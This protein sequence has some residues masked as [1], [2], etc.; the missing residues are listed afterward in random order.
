[1]ILPPFRT[2]Q[3]YASLLLFFYALALQ[4][5]AFFFPVAEV[6]NDDLTY[7]GAWLTELVTGNRWA[8]LL[9]PPLLVAVA[10]ILAN[11]YAD[12]YRLSRTVS[13]F[14]GLLLVLL[15]GLS[16]AFHAFSPHQLCFSFLLLAAGNLG[17]TYKGQSPEV[18][19]FNAGFWLGA[20]SLL[21]P[22]YLL[23]VPACIVGISIFRTVDLRTIMQLLVGVAI[24]YFLAATYGYFRGDLPV[25][26]RGQLTGFGWL[27]TVTEANKYAL[28][29]ATLLC[30]PLLVV[31]ATA[32][33]SRLL[34]TI[35]GAK[36]VSFVYWLLFFTPLVG[37][38][39]GAV[40]VADAQLLAPV[41]GLLCGL[42]LVRQPD[43]QAEFYHLLFFVAALTLYTV[44]LAT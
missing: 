20:A 11:Q 40:K 33:R 9:T 17:S 12:R 22:T 18:A 32:T 44:S 38:V 10:G 23:F 6:A 15:W 16:P 5:P 26:Y 30:L 2:N 42:W 21:E 14:P 28:I 35:E 8:A 3:A 34:L 19:R 39:A 37:G 25:L 31:L 29:G 36:N 27:R 41:L 13:Q 24:A 43:A 1:M 7:F 4:A